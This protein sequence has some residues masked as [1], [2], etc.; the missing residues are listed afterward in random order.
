MPA[1]TQEPHTEATE[2]GKEIASVVKRGTETLRRVLPRVGRDNIEMLRVTVNEVDFLVRAA[3][4]AA[5]T[6]VQLDPTEIKLHEARLRGL[7]RII[8]LRKAAEPVMETGEVCELLGVSRET[9][10]KKVDRRQI[11]ALPKGGDRVF[12]AFQ[13]KD[14]AILEGLPEVLKALDTESIFTILSFLLSNNQDLDNR[15][16]LE[17]LQAGNIE[18]VLIEARTF[19]KHGA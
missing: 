3:Q 15:T 19:L 8:E 14:G 9:I 10:R 13:F 2:T 4:I 12:P 6:I 16:A 5:E 1:G 7:K 11:L 17:L 18:P